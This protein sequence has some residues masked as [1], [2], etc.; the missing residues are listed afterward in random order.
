MWIDYLDF[1][2]FLG[3]GTGWMAP[4]HTWNSLQGFGRSSTLSLIFKHYPLI[5]ITTC[6]FYAHHHQSW[7]SLLHT[8]HLLSFVAFIRVPGVLVQ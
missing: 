8:I 5:T 4:A 6:R 7:I 1:R 2:V 3:Y